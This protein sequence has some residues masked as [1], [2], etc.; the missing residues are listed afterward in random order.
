M[1]EKQIYRI[2]GMDCAE[3]VAALKHAL[4]DVA[5]IADLRFDVLNGKMTVVPSPV[6][7]EPETIIAAV[8]S[9]G[10][11]AA[12]WAARGNEEAQ[13]FWA[14]RGHMAMT[15]ASGCFMGAGLALHWVLHGSLLH[16]LGGGDEHGFPLVVT[17]LYAVGAV[18]GAWFV[19]PKAVASAR[20]LRP[21]MNLLMMV[22]VIG[23][24]PA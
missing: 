15:I 22:A 8:A 9:T 4:R 16:A 2:E 5:G 1:T 24:T 19:A 20:R 17:L 3:E 13:S 18:T 21:D 10:M 23:A 11:R 12:P 6:G 7:F 14:R